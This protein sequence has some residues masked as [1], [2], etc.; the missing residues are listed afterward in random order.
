MVLFGNFMYYP[1]FEF[2]RFEDWPPAFICR[3]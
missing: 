3:G 2:V 1:G